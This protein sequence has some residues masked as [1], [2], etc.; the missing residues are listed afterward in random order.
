MPT[1]L[2]HLKAL[3]APPAQIDDRGWRRLRRRVAHVRR[4]PAERQQALRALCERF[5]R[6]KTITAAAEFELDDDRRLTLAAL[7]CLPVL[8]LGYD[9][10]RGWD[11]VIVYPGQFRVRRH[12]HDED[13]GVVD[14]WDDE[15][16]GECWDRG[17]LILSWSDVREDLQ[18]PE[19]GFNV[20]VHEIAHK[21]D[22]L[23]G[24][25]DGTPP[26]P[27]PE[28]RAWIEA[29]Q[30]AYEQLCATLAAGDEAPIDAYAAEAPDEFF[31]VVSEYHYSAPDLLRQAMPAV[32]AALERFYGPSPFARGELQQMAQIP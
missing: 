23:D 21:L 24:A 2:A 18:Q 1:L 4:L 16:S 13:S 30:P 22:A 32:A 25:M 19:A 3:F 31:A 27:A 12:Q 28:R 26:L 15:L 14:E 7:C 8:S 17:P 20:V 10:L 11:Q 6:D 9:W 29:F 5:L